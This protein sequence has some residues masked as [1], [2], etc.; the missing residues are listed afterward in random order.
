MVNLQ[1][2]AKAAPGWGCAHAQRSAWFAMMGRKFLGNQVD[3]C[4]LA[5][6]LRLLFGGILVA[7]CG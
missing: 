2:A 3:D 7:S 6:F 4:G 5:G 1:W